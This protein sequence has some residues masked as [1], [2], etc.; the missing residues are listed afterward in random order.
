[1]ADLDHLAAIFKAYD[2][3]GTVSRP[4][5]RRPDRAHRR[6]VRPLRG[7]HRGRD[8]G[9]RGPRHAAQRGRAGG[10]VR[11]GCP[12]PGTRRRRPRPGSTDLLYFAAGSLD[13]PGAMFTASHNPA[14]Y[15]GIKLC[16]SGAR[17]VGEDTGLDR[18]PGAR[19]PGRADPAGQPGSGRVGRHARRLRRARP[20][21]RRRR[22]ARPAEGGGRHGER[23]GRPGRPSRL[24]HAAVRPRGHVRRARRHV[25]QPPGRSDPA[26]EPARPAGPGARDRRRRRPGVRRRRRPGVPGRRPGRA[27]VGVDDD[28]HRGQGHPR[29]GAGRHHPLQPHLLEGRARDRPRERRHAGPHPGR[30]L[31]HQGG[32]GRD[33]RGLRRRALGALLLPRQLAGR[34]G[35]HRR[36]RRA[37]ADLQG[38]RPAVDPAQAVRPLRR[39]R[40]RSTP[41]STTPPRSSSG[42]RRP[43]PTRRR[44][45]STG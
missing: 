42:S 27:P 32:H 16:L 45:A 11:R 2:V 23:H 12:A 36:P 37:R 1:M 3:R 18:H 29:Q 39:P 40:A 30:P 10:R 5:R 8:A 41:P 31:V 4:D 17:P 21:L 6:G 44:I 15:N 9:A 43:T 35:Q 19:P 34:L 25:P 33:G 22:G 20:Q 26:R 14:Q 13:A 28:R 7:R 38:R 24:Q